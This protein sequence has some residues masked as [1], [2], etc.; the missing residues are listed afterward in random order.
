[1]RKPPSDWLMRYASLLTL[2]AAYFFLTVLMNVVFVIYDDRFASS[3][4]R[5]FSISI[6][7]VRTVRYWLLLFLPFLVVPPVAFCAR[8]VFAK[9]MN[10]LTNWVPEFRAADYLVIAGA[11]YAVVGYAMYRADAWELLKSGSDAISSV[12]ARFELLDR[13]KFFERAI[14]QSVLVF[15]TLYSLV[16]AR[17]SLCPIWMLLFAANL[18]LIATLLSWL[19]MKWPI[20]VLFGGIVACSALFGRYRVISS[21]VAGVAMIC[22]YLLIA[23]VVL[24]ISHPSNQTSS[25][26]QTSVLQ[27]QESGVVKVVG[28]A[29]SS[30]SRLAISGLVRMALPY[31]FYYRTFTDEGAVCGS[32][33]D[34]IIRRENPCQPS[35]L[36]YEKM[37]IGDGFA[38]R[39]TAPA[40]FNISGYALDG[41]FGA[42]I[43]TVLAGVLIGAFMAVPAT[44]SAMAGAVS[45]MGILTAYFLSQLPIEGVV[46][47]DHGFLW[48]LLLVLAYGAV[49]H[50]VVD[51]RA[52]N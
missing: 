52:P 47:Y 1:M 12:S 51:V 44:R 4:I 29:I 35:L 26:N 41:W 10:V 14:L 37:F 28:A 5:E 48:W 33:I 34:R 31:P 24:R 9:P 16:R 15:L 36:I 11:C 50:F 42:L 46:I 7:P 17:C 3:S 30:S 13:L 25:S 39:G 22:V 2:L 23:T 27:T 38:G 20:V 40:A 21:I 45:V 8:R 43:E 6:F 19:N 49:R 32:I 18:I